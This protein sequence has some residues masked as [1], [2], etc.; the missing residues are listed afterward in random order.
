MKSI[1]YITASILTIKNS[2][3]APTN[4]ANAA[5]NYIAVLSHHEKRSWPQIFADMGYNHNDLTRLPLSAQFSTFGHYSRAFTLTMSPS[6]KKRLESLPYISYIERNHEYSPPKPVIHTDIPTNFIQPQFIRMNTND[7]DKHAPNVE[8]LT[9]RQ[10]QE[11]QVQ[12]TQQ[13]GAPYLLERISN[14]NKINQNG[15]G[16]TDMNYTY[17]V[18][19]N[20]GQGVDVYDLDSGIN[21]NHVEFEGRAKHLFTVFGQDYEDRFGHGSHTAGTIGSR[22]Y[23]VAKNVTIYNCRVLDAQNSGSAAWY[24]Q[25]LEAALR[26]HEQRKNETSFKGSVVN[27]S[28]AG[29]NSRYFYDLIQRA[30]NS[31]MHISASAGNGNSDACTT[32]P[33]AWSVDMALISVGATDINDQRWESSNYGRCVTLHAPGHYIMSTYNKGPQSS[34]Y[35]SGTSMSAPVVSGLIADLLPRFPEFKLDPMGMKHFLERNGI[36]DVLGG[37][38]GGNILVNNMYGRQDVEANKGSNY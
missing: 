12:F 35:M 14:M 30:L 5:S 4:L 15:R 16:V 6:E 33:A 3:A 36:H 26:N 18:D 17:T 38:S 10:Q 20:S 8:G 11:Q 32:Y 34:Q 9:R 28:F 31:G 27:M 22:A 21:I 1:I 37:V 7:T 19:E 13:K 2:L 29:E 25:G 23:G 24:S